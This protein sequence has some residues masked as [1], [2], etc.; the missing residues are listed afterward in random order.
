MQVCQISYPTVDN[1]DAN[2]DV[3]SA[4]EHVYRSF[5]TAVAIVP[6]KAPLFG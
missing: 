4:C 3:R 2:L 5:I 6:T 1:E